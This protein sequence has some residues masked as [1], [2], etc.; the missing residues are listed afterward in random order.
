ML[1]PLAYNGGPVFVD[2]SPMLTRALLPGSPAID[3][4]DPA[5]VP[6]TNGVPEFD[7]RGRPWSRVE[8]GRIDMGAV[9]SQANPLPGDYNFNGVVDAADYSVWRDTVGSTNDLRA[10]GSGAAAGVPDGVVDELDYDFWKANFGNV[11]R[12]WRWVTGGADGTAAFG[13]GG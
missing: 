12:G 2:G 6:G 11:L 10:D 8:G 4:G 3:A 7:Q 13:R 5:A 1:G 9:E